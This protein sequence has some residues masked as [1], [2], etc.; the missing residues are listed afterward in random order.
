ML[1]AKGKLFA[2]GGANYQIVT[3]EL[4]ASGI[5]RYTNT[6]AEIV[7]YKHKELTISDK[8]GSIPREIILPNKT[9]L[10][11]NSE[12][13]LDHWLSAGKKD[14]NHWE[15]SPKAVISSIIAVPVTLYFIFA[16]VIPQMAVAFAPY[17]P[18]VLVELSSRHT[19][20][21][22]DKTVLNPSEADL[23]K[24]I[25]LEEQWYSLLANMDLEH[26]K[27]N[28]LFRD[29]KMMGPNAFAL[30]NGTIVF[31]DQLLELVDYDEEILTA[32]FMHEIGHVENYH[33]MR[34][35][36][37]TLATSIAITYIFGDVSGFFDFFASVSNTIATNQFTQ[38]LEW[39]ADEFALQQL[40]A[41]GNDPVSF[42]RGMKKF[43][44]YA[45]S[46]NNIITEDL[47]KILSSHPLTK[48]RISNALEFA[49]VSESAFADI[50]A[51]IQQ[52]KDVMKTEN[53][54]EFKHFLKQKKG[55]Q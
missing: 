47:E 21:A 14:V 54:A 38:K 34:L 18:D 42:A 3:V 11:M 49:G 16:V 31:T 45:D 5:L 43:A 23:E 2:D 15:K 10:V 53:D 33:S 17:V 48:E 51:E 24:T 28:I 39:E 9:L 30:P 1:V 19:M 4:Y 41:T 6:T 29:T 7:E 20:S 25:A 37:Q 27:Y 46:E 32:I 22:M 55:A 44:E 8:L 13:S 52:K 26:E 36:S 40:K 50:E 12:S 35:I